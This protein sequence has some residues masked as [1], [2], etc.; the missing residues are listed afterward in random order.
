MNPAVLRAGGVPPTARGVHFAAPPDGRAGARPSRPAATRAMARPVMLPPSPM[1]APDATL[2]GAPATSRPTPV[3]LRDLPA[4][5]V[6][7]LV[8]MPLSMGIAL[9]SGAP[10]MA[11]LISAAIGGLVVGA[12]SGVPLQVSGAAAGLAVMV[13]TQIERFGFRTVLAIVVAAGAIQLAL[14]FGKVARVT[15]AISPAVIHGMLAGI[16]VQI[17]LAQLHV[18][19]GGRPQSSALRNVAELPRQVENV[20]GPAM[21]LGLLTIGVLVAWPAVERLVGPRLKALPGPLVAVCLGTLAALHWGGDVPRVTV[22]HDWR[23]AFTLP[24]LPPAAQL[25]GA[26]V[27]AVSLAVVASAESL[28]SAIATDKMHAGPR[29]D[30]DR[31]LVAQGVGNMLAGL[32]GGLPVTGV[33]VRSTANISAGAR[34]RL[35]TMLHGL[36]TVV[37]VTQLA[38]VLNRIPL[39]VLAGLLCVVGA[40]LVSPA[41]IREMKKHRQLAIYLL[42]LGGVVGINLLAGIGIGIAAAVAQLLAKLAHVEIVSSHEGPR[43]HIVVKGSLTFLAVP[44]L[45]GA[46]AAVPPQAHVDLDLDVEVMDHAAWESIHAWRANH[47]KTGGTVDMDRIHEIWSA[48]DRGA[49]AGVPAA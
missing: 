21:L 40:R 26:I 28:L 22:P 33:I 4:S 38:F 29:A 41:H 45:S 14:G 31:E 9:A 2:D 13:F 16:G 46:L 30:L 11:G 23:S 8:A 25:G 3:W 35:S 7:F 15:L 32:C 34:T 12:L 10:I 44:K 20:H 24:V 48:A 47:E 18:V 5:L 39:S 1:H 6:T 36:W 37:F 49:R 42:T 17:F 43:W 27:A 19:L